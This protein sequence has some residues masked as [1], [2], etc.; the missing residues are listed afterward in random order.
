M[1]DRSCTREKCF[2]CADGHC[3][4]IAVSVVDSCELFLD[5]DEKQSR[6]PMV[7]KKP[8]MA[9]EPASQQLRTKTVTG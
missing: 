9:R 8:E 6:K 4:N 1:G 5:T 3:F 7:L 2:Y